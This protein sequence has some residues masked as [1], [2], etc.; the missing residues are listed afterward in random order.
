MGK[1]YKNA[2]QMIS[3]HISTQS[4]I[5]R[6]NSSSDLATVLKVLDLSF[7]LKVFGV[8]RFSV[9]FIALYTSIKLILSN[10]RVTACMRK[11]LIICSQLLRTRKIS[12]C[13]DRVPPRAN[14]KQK[15]VHFC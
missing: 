12:S 14:K 13:G 11:K 6:R 8:N 5:Y 15:N 1:A 3:I 4:E 9:L 7:L 10:T 2:T